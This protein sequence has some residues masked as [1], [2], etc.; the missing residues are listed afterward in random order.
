MLS[1]FV[2]YIRRF[3]L[4]KGMELYVKA[5]YGSG[6]HRL[7]VPGLRGPLLLRARTSDRVTFQN[8]FVD[9]EYAFE[10][11][12]NPRVIIDGGANVGYSTLFF[13]ERYSQA[14]VI[15]VEPEAENFRLLTFN[16]APYP[17]VRPIQ[18]ALWPRRTH[19]V[20]ENPHGE[21]Y[22]FRV[23]ETNQSREGSVP[24]T[25]IEE[26]LR[27]VG[28]ESLDL[29]KLDIEGSE[30]ELFE[31]PARDHWLA[32]NHALIVEL[33]DG[34]K[35]GC[36]QA[37]EQAV[38]KYPYRRTM[39]GENVLLIRTLGSGQSLAFSSTDPA[40]QRHRPPTM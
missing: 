12:I 40:C 18:K 20:M 38:A 32:R 13:A 34:F 11:G 36:S 3:G 14:V 19:L 24:T 30:K 4:F 22:T 31:D 10:L 9:G 7:S 5:K 8:I 39:L 33:H 6:E 21:P 26:L 1:R 16:T 28:A 37:F 35:P 2:R 25:T 23:R 17:N 15:A 27:E 29:L